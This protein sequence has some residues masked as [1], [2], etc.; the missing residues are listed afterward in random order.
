MFYG[1]VSKMSS[2]FGNTWGYFKKLFRVVTLALNY[3]KY[4]T[5][6]T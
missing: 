3:I 1:A 5:P 4:V 6:V 2:F